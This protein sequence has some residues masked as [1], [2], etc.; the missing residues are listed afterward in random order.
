[1]PPGSTELAVLAPSAVDATGVDGFAF[2]ECLTGDAQLDARQSLAPC[3]R[4]LAVAFHTDQ[5]T[6]APDQLTPGAFDLI[7]DARVDLVLDC[8]VFCP[9]AGHGDTPFCVQI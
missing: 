2:A 4:D 7:L 9:T 3:L 5:R 8:P 1:G 6:V